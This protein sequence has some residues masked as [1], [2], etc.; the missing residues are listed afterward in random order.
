MIVMSREEN[1]SIVIGD[2][3]IVRILKIEGNN[4]EIEIENPDDLSISDGNGE[5]ENTPR[6]PEN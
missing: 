5:T 1:Q 6:N 4:V 2:N 3:V